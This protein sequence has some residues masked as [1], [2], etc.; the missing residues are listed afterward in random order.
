V[1]LQAVGSIALANADVPLVSADR[2]MGG[3]LAPHLTA[4]TRGPEGVNAP[5]AAPAGSG[6]L[7]WSSPPMKCQYQRLL[8]SLSGYGHSSVCGLP[9]YAGVEHVWRA[10]HAGCL[11][12]V[13]VVCRHV[14][15]GNIEPSVSDKGGHTGLKRGSSPRP[16]QST[17]HVMRD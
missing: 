4:S 17:N 3:E 16:V 7:A 9:R 2:A 14:M 15:V 6:K 12:Y 5:S 11:M 1:S 10:H 8:P 13:G